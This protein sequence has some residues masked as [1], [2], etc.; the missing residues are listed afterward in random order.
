MG[1]WNK[2]GTSSLQR[3]SSEDH[4][5]SLSRTNHPIVGPELARGALSTQEKHEYHKL[6]QQEYD[7]WKKG[8]E[9]RKDIIMTL[10]DRCTQQ[11]WKVLPAAHSVEDIKELNCKVTGPHLEIIHKKDQSVDLIHTG[12][13]IHVW[14]GQG[15]GRQNQTISHSNRRDW[16][17]PA[18]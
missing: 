18:N 4:N 14:K 15:L 9:I 7:A 12:K 16:W 13:T 1:K 10:L 3:C 2:S 11:V 6:S 8:A 5:A 17:S